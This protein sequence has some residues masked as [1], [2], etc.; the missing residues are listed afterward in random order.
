M[1]SLLTANQ[2]WA[3]RIGSAASRIIMNLGGFG[4]LCLA[5]ADSS[6]LSLP[7][8]NDLLIVILST[9]KSWGNMAYYAGMTIIGS[10]I[11]C[12]LLYSVGR[13]G[14]GPL[15][16]KKFSQQRI[17]RAERLFE[18]Y[19]ILTVVIPSILPPPMPFKIFVLSAGVFQMKPGEFLVAVIV[20][21]T[22]RYFTWGI[23]A[24]LYGDAVKLYMQ[25]NLNQIGVVLF[26]FFGLALGLGALY[27]F[28][29]SR[30]VR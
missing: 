20:G 18:K 7:E 14:G 4:V 30:T 21:R 9:G 16:R 22:I 23:L 15:L 26:A 2:H 6:F 17:E 11:G 28:R 12:F 29:R 19:G 13:K 1:L 27:L 25:Q 5:I 8:G 3:A 10:V 24:V